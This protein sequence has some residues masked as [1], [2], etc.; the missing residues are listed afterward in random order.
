[1]V[2][3][4]ALDLRLPEPERRR[5][6]RLATP[7]A[8]LLYV[9]GPG[10]VSDVD[11]GC[12]R[13]TLFV[14]LAGGDLLRVTSLTVPAFGDS[15]CRL[16]LEG[17]AGLRMDALGSFFEP[18]RQGLVFAFTPDRRSGAVWPPAD[19][20][21]RY[22]GPPLRPPFEAGGRVR[23]LRETGRLPDGGVWTADRAL[24]IAC[25]DGRE[26]LVLAVPDDAERVAFLPSLGPYRTLVDPSAPSQ[27]G[28]DRRELLGYGRWDTPPDLDIHLLD[29]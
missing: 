12:Y 21:W 15:L 5:A 19:A 23:V 27:P 10:L 7:W 13:T 25:G 24:V 18:S 3:G 9:P 22:E 26:A 2:V 16:R 11:P 17:V 28:A 6:A 8:D 4:P 14:A 20:T 1:V 29:P